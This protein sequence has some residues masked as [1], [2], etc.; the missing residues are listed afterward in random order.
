[1]AICKKPNG[2]EID[3]DEVQ[4]DGNIGQVK[5]YKYDNGRKRLLEMDYS[6]NPDL[7]L[8]ELVKEY[9]M[10]GINKGLTYQ[11]HTCKKG[12]AYRL[13]VRGTN[14]DGQFTSFTT[15]DNNIANLVANIDS[16]EQGVLL[17]G[18]W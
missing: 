10:H 2:I 18:E 14:K 9:E 3:I 15:F 11:S 4:I 16:M 13:I 17:Y 5:V 1:M 7:L 6:H 12:H 8:P